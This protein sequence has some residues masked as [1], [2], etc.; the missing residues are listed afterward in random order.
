MSGKKLWLAVL[1]C[2]VIFLPGLYA[3][4]ED[5]SAGEKDADAGQDEVDGDFKTKEELTGDGENGEYC[6][7]NEDCK[8]GFCETW[9]TAPVDPDATC[10]KGVPQGEIRILGNVRDF[11]TD[12]TIAGALVQIAGAMPSLMDPDNA[13]VLAEATTDKDGLFEI[14]GGEMVTKE[15]VGIGA[16]INEDGYHR[17]ITGLVEPEIGGRIYPP[18]VRNHDLWA[19]PKSFLEDMTDVLGKEDVLS[20]YM[21]FGPNG[22]LT[23]RIR[24][25][26]TGEGVAGVNLISRTDTTVA[27]IYYL[28]GDRVRKD[29]SGE[30]GSPTIKKT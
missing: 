6:V 21:P 11:V 18:G 10:Q 24:N 14:L 4:D 3:C 15:T 22:G 7:V 1:F 12:E 25:V 19:I 9:W 17:T 8:S 27:L 5:G 20:S 26:D 2:Q 30:T 29:K 23:G 28:D 16:L 13:P